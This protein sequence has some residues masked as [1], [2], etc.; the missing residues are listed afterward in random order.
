MNAFYMCFI[1]GVKILVAGK[2]KFSILI[3]VYN[4]ENYIHECLNSILDQTYRNFEIIIIN[5]G[6][7]DSSGNI[8]DHYALEDARIR[9]F[10]Q[11]N[12]GL[13]MARRNAIPQARGD[14]CLFLDSDDY[15]DNNLLETVYETIC[16]YNCD[17]I[18]FRYSRVSEDG[19]V[20]S[21]SSALFR[22]NMIFEGQDK[23]KIFKKMIKSPTLNNLV[24]KAV[25]RSLIDDKD[26]SVYQKLDYG[27]DL[28]QS[29]PL[30]YNAKK[31]IYKDNPMYNYRMVPSSITQ[32]ININSFR[33]ITIAWSTLLRYL[34]MLELD[35]QDNLK[36][37]YQFCLGSIIKDIFQLATSNFAKDELLRAFEKIK[38]LQLYINSLNYIETSKLP[39]K[40]RPL[41]Y[42]FNK[43]H[44]QLLL[45]YARTG[46]FV[47][48]VIQKA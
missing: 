6:S 1:S 16:D 19:V 48:R 21:D 28:L 2:I 23:K 11:K 12:Q 32:K 7:T 18:I 8:C 41:F 47:R 17:L 30:I 25:K 38:S 5:D 14:F 13:L 22:D 31:I 37:F 27:E 33:D 20:I 9:V 4:V 15:W 35:D 43:S 36:M 10:H 26:Y 39:L 29:I 34:R 44:Y 42:F 3:P 45:L 24:C 46:A 40:Y